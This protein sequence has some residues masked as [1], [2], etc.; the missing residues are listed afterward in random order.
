[1]EQLKP[2]SIE[3]NYFG[4]CTQC[5]A[6]YMAYQ[7]ELGLIPQGMIKGEHGVECLTAHGAF[8]TEC[9]ELILFEKR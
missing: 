7:G 9:G 8:C 6:E 1:M 5:G 3:R 2:A 4:R